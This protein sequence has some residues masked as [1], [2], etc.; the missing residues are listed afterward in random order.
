[1][2]TPK[3]QF[4]GLKLGLVKRYSDAL[5]PNYHIDEEIRFNA[6]DMTRIGAP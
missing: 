4:A 3:D 6:T 5:L 2:P 1:M